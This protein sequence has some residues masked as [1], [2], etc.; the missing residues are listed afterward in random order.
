ML[1]L[2][3]K[4]TTRGCWSRLLTIVVGLSDVDTH[5]CH[6]FIKLNSSNND[7]ARRNRSTSNSTTG[8]FDIELDF[9]MKIRNFSGMLCDALENGK[10]K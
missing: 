5:A 8:I 4:W 7:D 10:R 2:E 6:R 3:R 9:E 1:G